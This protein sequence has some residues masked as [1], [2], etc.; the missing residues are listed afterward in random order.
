MV[1][2]QQLSIFGVTF[3]AMLAVGVGYRT[4]SQGGLVSGS[5]IRLATVA[6]AAREHVDNHSG[7][8]TRFGNRTAIVRNGMGKTTPLPDETASLTQEQRAQIQPMLDSIESI[9][10]TAVVDGDKE[11]AARAARE[12]SR[13]VRAV[14]GLQGVQAG[15]P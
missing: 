14:A 1:T 6:G 5:P 12:R 4:F 11:L 10:E 13:L 15:N 8:P 9:E 2:R 3:A 7:A